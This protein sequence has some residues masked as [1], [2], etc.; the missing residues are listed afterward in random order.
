MAI[1]PG[2]GCEQRIGDGAS[3]RRLA[4]AYMETGTGLD[5]LVQELTRTACDVVARD[6]RG[7]NASSFGRYSEQEL[8]AAGQTAKSARELAE[9]ART[10]ADGLDRAKSLYEQAKVKA[11]EGMM[12]ITDSCWLEPLTETATPEQQAAAAEAWALLDQAQAQASAARI[13]FRFATGSRS[14]QLSILMRLT[15]GLGFGRGAAGGRMPGPRPAR[16]S[17]TAIR[18]AIAKSTIPPPRVTVDERVTTRPAVGSRV[19]GPGQ[20]VESTKNSRSENAK[21]FQEQATGVTRD[22]EYRV[23]RDGKQVDFDGF[24]DGKLLD[25]KSERYGY[26]LGRKGIDWSVGGK[27]VDE[28]QRQIQVAPDWPIEWRVQGAHSAGW[29]ENLLRD[30]GVPT[31][32]GPGQIHVV[33]FPA[34]APVIW[35]PP[36]KP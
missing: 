23:I 9:A 28:A 14:E 32:T 31:G 22:R 33:P 12:A 2:C 17:V 11:A 26:Q 4:N 13:Q 15:G 25:A 34:D 35:Q 36:P 10:L 30:A 5:Q 29:I 16:S 6:W 24:A 3:I 20:W 21:A 27:L 7:K 18:D 1:G 19:G 8:K